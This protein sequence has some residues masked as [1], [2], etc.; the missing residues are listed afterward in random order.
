V[1]SN[2]FGNLHFNGTTQVSVEGFK[3]FG[4][5][6]TGVKVTQVFVVV[7]KTCGGTQVRGVGLVISGAGVEGCVTTGSEPIGANGFNLPSSSG[8]R[9]YSHVN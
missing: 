4:K 6:H 9:Y 7:S 2:T 1:V 3:T 5:L 8:S